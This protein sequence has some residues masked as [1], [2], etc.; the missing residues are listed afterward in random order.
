MGLAKERWADGSLDEAFEY[1]VCAGCFGDPAIQAF[2]WDHPASGQRCSFCDGADGKVVAWLRSVLDFIVEGI[3]R[4]YD[5]AV[6]VSPWDGGYIWT[7][8]DSRELLVE[9]L[10]L[11][12]PRDDGT[13]MDLLARCLAD[14]EWCERDYAVLSPSQ[15]L[16]SSWGKFR[17]LVSHGRRYFFLDHEYVDDSEPDWHP[18]H[19]LSPRQVLERVLAYTQQNELIRDLPVGTK[20]YRARPENGAGEHQ[21]PDELGPPPPERAPPG[22]MSPS[23]VPVLYCALERETAIAE[24]PSETGLRALGCFETTAAIRILDLSRMLELPSIFDPERAQLREAIRFLQEFAEEIS[25]PAPAGNPEP[26]YVPTQVVTEYV[27]FVWQADGGP[28]HGICYPSARQRGGRNVA[29]FP[30]PEGGLPPGLRLL[31]VEDRS[32]E[33]A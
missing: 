24:T 2:I 4:E 16:L 5:D 25:Q 1:F 10:E 13:L 30:P 18:D 8:T 7:T 15:H 26:S 28:I 17:Q 6:E 20:L 29:L 31:S 21:T 11:E 19:P 22:R 3:H 12:L 27:R 14:V 23:G 32:T 9:V 33:G